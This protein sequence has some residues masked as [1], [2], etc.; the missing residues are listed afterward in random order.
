MNSATSADIPRYLGG[1]LFLYGCSHLI[2]LMV[3]SNHK[4]RASPAEPTE[5]PYVLLNQNYGLFIITIIVHELTRN[6]LSFGS[7]NHLLLS[8]W[9]GRSGFAMS[10]YAIWCSAT[11]VI[12]IICISISKSPP[13]IGITCLHTTVFWYLR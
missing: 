1:F 4:H 13:K 9:P 10:N 6:V 3:R 2:T 12:H 7:S 11:E 5:R 8:T